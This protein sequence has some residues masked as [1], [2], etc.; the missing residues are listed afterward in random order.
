MEKEFYEIN[1]D[2]IFLAAMLN[3][4]LNGGYEFSI[5]H[6]PDNETVVESSVKCTEEQALKFYDKVKQMGWR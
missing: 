1:F 6:N 3:E 4:Y 2:I 5:Y